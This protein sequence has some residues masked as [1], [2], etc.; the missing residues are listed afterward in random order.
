M[1]IKNLILPAI[2]LSIGG[3]FL[4]PA[5]TV[6]AYSLL[7]WSLPQSQ[8]DFRVYNNF[9]D[10]AANNNQTP[11][12]AFPGYQ[13]AV[14]AIWKGCVE[15]GS[16]LHGDGSG[17]PHQ[18]NGLGSGGANFDPS[19][20]GLATGIGSSSENIHSEISGG[21]GGVLAYTEGAGGVGWR[22]RYYRNWTW[23]D[24]P[25]TNVSG[26]DLQ[27]VACHEYGHALGMGHTNTGGATMYPSISGSGVAQRSIANDDINGVKA[28]YSVID[29]AKPRI[30]S[31][32][33]AGTT[34]TVQGANFDPAG[35]QIWFTQSTAGGN[36]TPVKAI[37]L[38]SN[39]SVLSA[40]I[41][42]AAGPGDVL[43][44]KNGTAHKGLSNAW[45][46]DLQGGGGSCVDP[47]NYCSTSPNS[48]GGGATMSFGGTPSLT[49]NDLALIASGCPPNKNGLFYYGPNQINTPFGN[50]RRCVGGSITRLSTLTTDVFGIAQK[51]LDLGNP[52]FTSGNGQAIPGNTMNFQF[53]YRDPAGGG[54]GYNL[55]DGLAVTFCP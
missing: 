49:A 38:T 44:R 3:A 8:R 48:V 46:T 54:A 43:V 22:I 27:G 52:P 45:P 42:A 34:I 55:T 17:D 10:T 19:F 41:P 40:T 16:R 18:P 23:N 50:G 39:G 35:N 1:Q 51:N 33:I 13:G 29:S 12:P 47:V 36:G 7:G 53:W 20:Q 5:Q 6:E 25:G 21:S 28:I 30:N 37:D 4:I 14:M 9:T 31:I 32:S 24:G 2:A 11:D 26:I 15:W